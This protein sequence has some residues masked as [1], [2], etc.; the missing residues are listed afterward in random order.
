MDTLNYI[1][2][3]LVIFFLALLLSLM[4]Y[5]TISSFFCWML[6][7]TTFFIYVSLLDFW[8]IILELIVVIAITVL[9][10]FRGEKL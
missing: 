1:L 10:Y 2:I 9:D 3:I 7:F 6:I 8:I 5:K 4:T